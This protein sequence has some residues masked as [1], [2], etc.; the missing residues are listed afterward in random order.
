M[1]L[2]EY[3]I[4]LDAEGLTVKCDAQARFTIKSG[5]RTL[6]DRLTLASSVGG[7]ITVA[8]IIYNGL[9]M[10]GGTSW[11]DPASGKPIDRPRVT[12]RLRPQDVL[13]DGKECDCPE[14][15][16]KAA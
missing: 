11:R 13:G 2:S 5:R 12:I 9:S 3:T 8:S 10:S 14:H 7:A 6:E 15:R 16:R 1:G 4:P